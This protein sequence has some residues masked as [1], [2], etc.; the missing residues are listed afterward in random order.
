M[1]DTNAQQAGTESGVRGDTPRIL[2]EISKHT[3][4]KSRSRR[5][6]LKRFLILVVLLVPVIL[7]ISFLLWEQSRTDAAL[8]RLQIDNAAMQSALENLHN[9]STAAQVAL[10][11]N[12]VDEDSLQRLRSE[13]DSRLSALA[14]SDAAL[15]ER[16]SALPQERA[17]ADWL[18]TEAETLLRLANQKL[19][20]EGD[21]DSALLILSEVDTLL[22]DSG[23]A[24]VLG[25]RDLL[26][27]EMLALR[28]RTYVDVSG[29]YLRVNN[30]LPLIDQLSLRDA[31]VANYASQLSVTRDQ[32]A[33]SDESFATR[34]LNL[35]RAIFVW[36]EWDVAPEALLP[37]QQEAMLKQNLHL[38]L[39]QAQLALLMAEPEIYRDS[40]GKSADW[41]AQYFAIDRGVG[42]TLSEELRALSQVTV[43]EERPDISGSLSLLRQLN[44]ART[45][46][47]RE[48]GR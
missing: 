30:L 46:S 11:E 7:S 31:M 47:E 5:S 1:T 33:V 48:P 42:R 17:T 41:T 35:L 18:W 13:L 40:M 37:P 15:Q 34:A 44:A 9:A 45:S 38:M 8:L 26:A 19:Q 36:Q 20:L 24:S 16:L 29:L 12:L 2:D 14:R 27:S 10:P 22:R 23:E 21:G 3:N 32:T 25:V 43:R 4:A 28:N 39:E 6:G